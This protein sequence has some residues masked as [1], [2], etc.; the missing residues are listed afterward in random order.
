MEIL[1]V[2]GASP[3]HQYPQAELTSAQLADWADGGR[4]GAR[5]RELHASVGVKTRHLTLPKKSYAMLAD[6]TAA[7]RQFRDVGFELAQAALLHFA[8]LKRGQNF[9]A[10][11]ILLT[12][13]VKCTPQDPLNAT[14]VMVLCS[15]LYASCSADTGLS[16]AS[17]ERSIRLLGKDS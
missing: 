1:A 5:V 2:Q 6:F 8:V 9:V 7:N 4:L 17:K 10:T 15:G 12:T 16:G 11:K 13:G 3:P 14:G